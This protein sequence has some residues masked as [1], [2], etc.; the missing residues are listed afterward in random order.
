MDA[1]PFYGTMGGQAGDTG[2]ITGPEGE[3]RVEDT[4]H[5]R[6]GRIGH[7]GT[8]TKGLLKSGDAVRL[9]VDE[10]ARRAT[11]RNHSATHLMQK[12]LKE[13]L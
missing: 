2:I 5:L 13:V 11:A 8:V 3:F 7:V 4:I 9:D 12:A 10:A 6:G 1:T